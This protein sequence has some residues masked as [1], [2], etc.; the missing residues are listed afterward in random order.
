MLT[1]V[2]DQR[3]EQNAKRRKLADE[4]R[5]RQRNSR[6]G[7]A[8]PDTRQFA[9]VQGDPVYMNAMITPALKPGETHPLPA[10]PIFRPGEL[11]DAERK[12][13]NHDMIVNRGA[14][15]AANMANKSAAAALK[16]QLLAGDN[17]DVEMSDG[18]VE[19][20]PM[21]IVTSTKRKAGEM[22][23]APPEASLPDK[24]KAV[25]QEPGTDTVRCVPSCCL[26]KGRC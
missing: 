1:N 20:K 6:N 10:I 22:T 11:T 18:K 5:D 14:I 26:L 17:K 23:D 19:D 21:P 2:V 13:Q 4:E 7:G 15:K 8:A 16:S 24:P 9:A 25:E 3:R 12:K